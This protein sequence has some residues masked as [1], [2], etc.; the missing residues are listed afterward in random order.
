MSDS[1]L[2]TD[3]EFDDLLKKRLEEEHFEFT[4]E[5][6][7]KFEQ[8][9][10]VKPTS[11]NKSKIMLFASG[12]AAGIL[13]MWS[14]TYFTGESTTED[15]SENLRKSEF[16]E[17]KISDSKNEITDVLTKDENSD[18]V[19]EYE[20]S[21]QQD[22]NSTSVSFSTHADNDR[23]VLAEA[24]ASE[25]IASDYSRNLSEESGRKSPEEGFKKKFASNKCVQEGLDPNDEN[26]AH[27]GNRDSRKAEFTQPVSRSEIVASGDQNES[28]RK[29][30]NDVA[31]S[32]A[33]S[34]KQQIIGADLN[35]SASPSVLPVE[36]TSE[37][38]SAQ[39]ENTAGPEQQSGEEILAMA[40]AKEENKVETNDELSEVL[41]TDSR[42]LEKED[43]DEQITE[44]PAEQI[45]S[46]EALEEKKGAKKAVPIG[47]TIGLTGNME[48]RISSSGKIVPFAAGVNFLPR[49]NVGR[50]LFGIGVGYGKYKIENAVSLF[51]P[52]NEFWKNG[53]EPTHITAEWSD[54]RVPIELSYQFLSIGAKWSFW[55]TIRTDNKFTLGESYSFVYDDPD[56]TLRNNWAGA[57]QHQHFISNFQ[58]GGSVWYLVDNNFRFGAEVLY[59]EN[60]KGNALGNID[61]NG[62]ALNIGI[63]YFI[64]LN[65]AKFEKD[66]I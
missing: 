16:S 29:I 41:D 65:K 14:I 46:E 34:G 25:A 60:L 56:P 23:S 35:G 64:G 26:L 51:N 49:L 58:F 22:L 10:Q 53:I 24:S 20:G 54:V 15:I 55:G 43:L 36:N 9:Q 7:Q 5:K 42:E 44:L 31:Q 21:E 1:E 3:Q 63:T 59:Q 37:Q 33:I 52:G 27:S 39:L 47:L 2:N 13:L 57:N 12:M 11:S 28:E 19:Q 4:D 30:A 48:R 32:A 38:K 17:A 18:R 50:F 45:V 62:L 66:E 61:V 6:W 8:H 40:T